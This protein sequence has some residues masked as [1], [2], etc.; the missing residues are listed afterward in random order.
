MNLGDHETK[1]SPLIVSNASEGGP[2]LSADGSKVVF[3]SNRSGDSEIWTCAFQ[4]C[5]SPVQLTS[6]GV[7]SGTP[8]FS[9]DGK[10][11]AFDSRPGKHS[12]VLVI[13]SQGGVRHG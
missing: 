5:S 7:L 3:A 10:Y 8:R 9:P 1:E 6:L 11:I 12:Q 13:E 4:S 2:D